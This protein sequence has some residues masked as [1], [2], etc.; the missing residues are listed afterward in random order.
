M[1]CTLQQ[2][3]Q[4]LTLKKATLILFPVVVIVVSR[5]VHLLGIRTGEVMEMS[6]ELTQMDGSKL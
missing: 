5:S 3:A 6:P 1:Q 2:I 4:N